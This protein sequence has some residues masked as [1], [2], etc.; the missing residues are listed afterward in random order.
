M[1][2]V[3]PTRRLGVAPLR[4]CF[5][6]NVGGVWFEG[7]PE[8]PGPRYWVEISEANRTPASL[9]IYLLTMKNESRTMKNESADD[10][11]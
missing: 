3:A 11:K 1:E 6:K 10:E 4:K 9:Y 5:T 2:T 8:F 7:L